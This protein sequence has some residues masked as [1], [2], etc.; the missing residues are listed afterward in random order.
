MTAIQKIIAAS[1]L[2]FVAVSFHILFCDWETG[3]TH[4]G[5]QRAQRNSRVIIPMGTD[6]G[7][8]ARSSATHTI[9][10]ILGFALP[11]T[12]IATG[13]FILVGSSRNDPLLKQSN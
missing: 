6:V 10:A 12:L 13:I 1:T 7:I 11:V 5:P 3:Q 9:D 8:H 2:A 4:G